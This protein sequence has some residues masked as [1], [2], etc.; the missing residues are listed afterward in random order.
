[1]YKIDFK[2]GFSDS[3]DYVFPKKLKWFL[4]QLRLFNYMDLMKDY[5]ESFVQKI[6]DKSFDFSDIDD[7]IN[8]ISYLKKYDYSKMIEK[9]QNYSFVDKWNEIIGKKEHIDKEDENISRYSF[10]IA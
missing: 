1:M 10:E 4:I 2:N 7:L 9:T 8:T 6:Y 5:K 3:N